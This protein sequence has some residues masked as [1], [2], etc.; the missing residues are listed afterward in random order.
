M[1]MGKA[2]LLLLG[3]IAN[4]FTGRIKSEVVP[5]VKAEIRNQFQQDNLPKEARF[6]IL[7]IM[8][9]VAIELKN[10]YTGGGGK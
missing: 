6:L 9:Q 1:D 3:V 10:E 4:N 7:D 8:E 2:M 5:I